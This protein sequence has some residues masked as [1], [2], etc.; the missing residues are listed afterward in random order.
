MRFAIAS[1]GVKTGGRRRKRMVLRPAGKEK[2]SGSGSVNYL[3]LRFA[4]LPG[5]DIIKSSSYRGLVVASHKVVDMSRC[6]AVYL[7]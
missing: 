2:V 4:L 3:I 1:H 7:D 5:T 6:Y